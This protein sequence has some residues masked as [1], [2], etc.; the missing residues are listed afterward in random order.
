MGNTFF[1]IDDDINIRKM[2]IHIISNNDLGKVVGELGSGEHAV[3][4]IQ[5]Y[6]PDIVLIDLLLPVIDG[7]QI[8]EASKAEGYQGKFIMI[9][10]VEDENLISKA[11][12]KGIIFFISKPINKI[13]Q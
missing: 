1:I 13:E 7:I 2:L 5:F 8:I 10:Q 9:S 6:N 12:E 3:K 11:Y 4:E